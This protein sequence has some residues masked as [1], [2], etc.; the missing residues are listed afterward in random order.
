MKNILRPALVVFFALTLVTLCVE[1]FGGW[2]SGSLALLAD[3]RPF[4]G[5]TEAVALLKQ[6]GNGAPERGCR[7][8]RPCA[9]ENVALHQSVGIMASKGSAEP[10][11]SQ[12]LTRM[13]P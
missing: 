9:Q 2:L 12:T 6:V 1:A 4:D 10:A 13:P 8:A 3:G 11:P 7:S 5:R